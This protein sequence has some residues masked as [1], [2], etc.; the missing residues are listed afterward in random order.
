MFLG[1]RPFFTQSV[2][3]T[4]PV[5]S[6]RGICVVFP[7][8]LTVFHVILYHKGEIPKKRG[9]RG[10]VNEQLTEQA[11]IT[12]PCA[13]LDKL[14]GHG[15]G[16]A[17]LLYL[18][19]LR[20]G[21]FSLGRASRELKCTEAELLAAITTLRTLNLLDDRSQMA[22]NPEAPEYTPEDI[23]QRVQE[24]PVFH[25]LVQEAENILGRTLSSNDLRLLFGIR[26]YW[27]LQADV[28]MELMHHC[29]EKYQE[30]NGIGRKPTMRYIE[31]EAQFWARNEITTLD[32]VEDYIRQG[33]EKQAVS[34]QIKELLQ[35][36]GRD[37]SSA[38]TAYVENW[39]ELGFSP[40]VNSIAYE[41][42]ILSTGKLAWRYM[43]RIL[44]TWHEKGLYT[45][46]A[47]RD[48]DARSP[49]P[50]PIPK[51]LGAR[52]GGNEVP[53]KDDDKLAAMRRMYEHLKRNGASKTAD[54][55]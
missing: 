51:P 29:L 39:L 49:K 28:T 13:E 37:F 18:H 46:E 55:S 17:A 52:S 53:R 9:K 19:I 31:K 47:I 44:Q 33:K 1:T 11:A 32:A 22:E 14:L 16:N 35:I 27:G 34:G 7:L 36:R 42:T 3:I 10:T 2:E 41:R 30:R 26:D 23:S 40:E 21:G 45:P 25:A 5:R 8:I 43:D 4:T 50:K 12:L 20:S 24:D 54:G 38:E 6:A 48:G 15:D